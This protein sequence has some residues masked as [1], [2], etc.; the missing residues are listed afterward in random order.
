MDPVTGEGVNRL[1]AKERGGGSI[2]VST[3]AQKIKGEEGEDV[4]KS[5]KS[6]SLSDLP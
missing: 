4:Q 2:K 5:L 1:C 6:V 3:Y